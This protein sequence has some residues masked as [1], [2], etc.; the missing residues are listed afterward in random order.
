[1][2]K[3]YVLRSEGE[4]KYCIEDIKPEVILRSYILGEGGINHSIKYTIF[5]DLPKVIDEV[6]LTLTTQE[7]EVLKHRFGFYGKYC[8][9]RETGRKMELTGERVRQIEKKVI[10]KLRNLIHS[11]ILYCV[12]KREEIVESEEKV[13]ELK[14]IIID[15]IGSYIKRDSLGAGFFINVLEKNELAIVFEN[16]IT[17]NGAN[18]IALEELEFYIRTYSCL[19]RAGVNTMADLLEMTEDDLMKVR[20]L[21]RR[22]AEEVLIKVKAYKNEELNPLMNKGF[23]NKYTTIKVLY[24]GVEQ[25]YKFKSMST[26]EMAECIYEV[27]TEECSKKGV[28]IDYKMS[29]ELKCLLLF[30][31]YFFIEN[32]IEDANH[33]VDEMKLG[34]YDRYADEFNTVIKKIRDCIDNEENKDTNFTIVKNKIAKNIINRNPKTRDELFGCF[35]TGD[36]EYD[37]DLRQIFEKEF[38]SSFEINISDNITLSELEDTEEL[39]REDELIGTIA[40]S[41]ESSGIKNYY[42]IKMKDAPSDYKSWLGWSNSNNALGFYYTNILQCKVFSEYTLKEDKDICMYLQNKEYELVS[43]K[44]IEEIKE[45]RIYY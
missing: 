31:G 45:S 17:G 27:L 18:D 23:S 37:N 4:G 36:D 12:P 25:V 24:K 21:G 26:S 7:V 11:R 30:K 9:L 8:S 38:P 15:K 35:K 14:S 5:R 22:S 42:M 41:E 19:K 20:N 6:F 10:R 28:I 44:N 32:V 33:I 40:D 39:E 2:Y 1:M 3:R 29:F 13:V 34:S 43:V 16:G